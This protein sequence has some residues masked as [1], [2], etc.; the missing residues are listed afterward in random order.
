MSCLFE[1]ANQKLS[2]LSANMAKLIDFLIPEYFSSV[3]GSD[4]AKCVKCGKSFAG[5]VVCN[6]ERHLQRQ[7]K[8]TNVEYQL[9]KKKRGLPTDK[10]APRKMKDHFQIESRVANV[11]VS[12]KA[13]RA[14]C[15]E[16][17]TKNNRPFSIIED[18]GMSATRLFHAHVQASEFGFFM[19]V[20]KKSST[21]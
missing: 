2:E 8:E 1:I 10:D 12:E 15:V 14:A 21:H 20:F 19:K 6:M 13:I 11:T 5:T 3:I 16:L 7:H 17:V 18:S 4:S 9:K